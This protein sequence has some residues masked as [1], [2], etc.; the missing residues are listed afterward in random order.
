MAAEAASADVETGYY[1]ALAPR[2]AW[3]LR[4]EALMIL[5]N[6]SDA[7]T[8]IAKTPLDCY[9]CVRVRGIVAGGMGNR[10]T[11]Q[12]WFAEAVR[13]A[14]RL[15]PAFLDWGRLLLDAGRLG[16][17]QD[18]LNQAARLAPHW[19]DPLKFLGDAFA[20]EGKKQ[21]A[22][23]KYDAALKLAPNW[24]ELRTARVRVTRGR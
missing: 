14:P 3:P 16:S 7:A 23:Q 11:A 24:T 20:A 21:E 15:A 4:A 10:M 12:K 5:G 8:L 19:A 2:V 6:Y 1:R 13:Q 17:A 9:T 18:K 22:L